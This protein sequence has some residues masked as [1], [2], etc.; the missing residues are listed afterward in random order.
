MMWSVDQRA[1]FVI[2]GNAHFVKVTVLGRE[3]TSDDFW[4]GNWL[5]TPIEIA[6]GAWRGAIR[7]DLRADE[8]RRFRLELQ[9]IYVNLSGTATLE[10]LDAWITLTV[11]CESNGALKVE[12][13]ADDEP[14]IEI[15]STSRYRTLTSRIFLR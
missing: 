1:E 6:A 10:S 11:Q 9:D 2:G 14:A 4:D 3:R 7:G 12:G 5:V 15:D 13:V 8:L